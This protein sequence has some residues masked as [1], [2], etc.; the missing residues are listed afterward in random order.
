MSRIG[1]YIVPFFVILISVAVAWLAS[2]RRGTQAAN[3]PLPVVLNTSRVDL[4]DAESRTRERLARN[5][6]DAKAG[7][8]LAEILLRKARVETNASHAIEAERVL[9]AVLKHEPAEYSALKLLGA[10]LLSQHRFAEAADAARRAMSINDRDAWSYGVLGDA[11]VELGRYDQAFDAF[12][13]MV[14][15]RPDAASYARVA[16]AHELQ[17]RLDEALRHL[18][19]ATEA[20]SAHDPESIAWHHAQIGAIF[21]QMGHI[22]AAARA[23][24]KANY[25]FPNHPYARSGMARVAAARGNYSHALALYRALMAEAPTPELAATIGDL[26]ARRGDER[27]AAAMYT[28]AEA[29]EREGWKTEEPQRAALARMLAERGL[30]V[31]EAVELAEQAARSRRDI[32]TMDA[33]AWAYF[34]AGRLQEA[35]AASREA[36]RTG[37]ADHRIRCHAAAIERATQIDGSV[38]R[39]SN[40]KFRMQNANTRCR[41]EQ[42][43][44]AVS[45]AE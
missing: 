30:K 12:D 27:E 39:T 18:Q 3:A 34:Q 35:Q 29:I 26:L 13:S 21:F 33:L 42:W 6:A 37:T 32:H 4:N 20:T 15:L 23:F 45:V 11:Y 24:A 5:A 7:V 28:K 14:R 16:Y 22:D 43:A 40:A 17:G 1:G 44:T 8:R 36:L 2:P 9:R 38:A 25:L 10:V 41:F 31:D 19:M